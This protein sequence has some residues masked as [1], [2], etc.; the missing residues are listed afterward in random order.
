MSN[1]KRE[2]RVGSEERPKPLNWRSP[3]GDDKRGRGTAGTI[4]AAS[5]LFCFTGYLFVLKSTRNFITSLSKDSSFIWGRSL[6]YMGERDC[7]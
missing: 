7:W 1:T 4:T 6:K 2:K 3:F 5:G